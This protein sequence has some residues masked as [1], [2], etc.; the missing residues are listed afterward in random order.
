MPTCSSR[1]T[2]RYRPSSSRRTPFS[3]GILSFLFRLL[4]LIIASAATY[5][6]LFTDTFSMAEHLEGLGS[7]GISLL[8]RVCMFLAAEVAWIAV[9][10]FGWDVFENRPA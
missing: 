1:D 4:V 6:L 3:G 5:G 7:P 10:F 8:V 2:D 9:L